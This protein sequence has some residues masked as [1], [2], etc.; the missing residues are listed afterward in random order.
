[1]T[2]QVQEVRRL[3]SRLRVTLF[4]PAK[5][6]QLSVL[7]EAVYDHLLNAFVNQRRVEFFERQQLE[8]ILREQKLIQTEIVDPA[9]AARIA[10]IM[11]VEGILMVSVTETP[12]AV[13]IFARFVDVETSVILAAE[14]VCGEDLTLQALRT[15]AESL[16]VKFRRRLPLVE[17]VMVKTEGRQVCVDLGEKQSIR[18]YMKLLLFQ[19]REPFKHPLTGK[20]LGTSTQTLGESRVEAVLEDFSQATMLQPGSS[21]EVGQLDKVI[22]K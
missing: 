20:P 12:Q 11:G 3:D 15:F 18:K 16:A 6:G 9:T 1:V 2:C 19:E 8:A 14:D 7:A 17:G 13:E 21:A 22:T 5:K 10:K 4:P